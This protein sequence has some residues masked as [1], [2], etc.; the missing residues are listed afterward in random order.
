[1]AYNTIYY[2]TFPDAVG[3]TIDVYIKQKDYAGAPELLE[4][5]TDPVIVTTTNRIYPE[6]VYGTGATIKII[7]TS[8][9][10]LKYTRL[11]GTPEKENYVLIT[12]DTST[13]IFEGYIIPD[14]YSQE[15]RNNAEISLPASNYLSSLDKQELEITQPN[16]IYTYTPGGFQANNLLGNAIWSTDLSIDIA[17]NNTVYSDQMTLSDSS[18][19]FDYIVIN[20]NLYMRENGE[21]ESSKFVIE[22]LLK[23]F[24]SRI[25]YHDGKF[26]IE[27]V[28][29]LLTENKTFVNYSPDGTRSSF[30]LP[31]ERISLCTDNYLIG[32]NTLEFESGKKCIDV[33][34]NY[35]KADNIL[36]KNIWEI[37]VSTGDKPDY[38]K[39]I[40]HVESES[41][42]SSI[43]YEEY[44]DRNIDNGVKLT[45]ADITTT[46]LQWERFLTTKIYLYPA[47]FNRY[48]IS[49]KYSFATQ[50]AKD[51]RTYCA[52]FRLRTAN[53]DDESTYSFVGRYTDPSGEEK[54]KWYDERD[55]TSA[56]RE[57]ISLTYFQQ[58]FTQ[59]DI[60]PHTGVLEVNVDVDLTDLLLDG[61][62]APN[63][64]DHVDTHRTRPSTYSNTIPAVEDDRSLAK[65]VYLD[66]HPLVYRVIG[67]NQAQNQTSGTTNTLLITDIFD[68]YYTL[69]SPNP[70]P[71]Y[72]NI[73]PMAENPQF[74]GD[75]NIDAQIDEEPNKLKGCT[76]SDYV[77]ALEVNL[78]VFDVKSDVYL[79]GIY[80]IDPSE[81]LVKQQ[82]WRDDTSINYLSIQ[83]LLIQDL[84]QQFGK[85][86][87]KLNID[88]KCKD[89]SLFNMGQV[90][91]YSYLTKDGSLME[92][93]PTGMEYNVQANSYRLTLLEA[94][95]D[96][97]FRIDASGTTPVPYM[98]LNPQF[99]LNP[100]DLY[101]YASGYPKTAFGNVV[102]V[103]TNIFWW[104]NS[105]IGDSWIVYDGLYDSFLYTH[106]ANL[107]VN[108]EPNIATYDA[109]GNQL[110][111]FARDGS[112]RFYPI[113]F[114]DPTEYANTWKIVTV[115]QDADTSALFLG[116]DKGYL[117]FDG[118]GNACGD[119]SIY[120]NT[121]SAWYSYKFYDV[122]WVTIVDPSASGSAIMNLT[123][124]ANAGAGIRYEHVYVRSYAD[125]GKICGFTI[126][127]Y[128]TGV[129]C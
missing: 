7:N 38:G 22:S 82:Y 116:I 25:Y 73:L 75:V 109:E 8:T 108:T 68:Y 94:V 86:R 92:F 56:S 16:Y 35:K 114:T 44:S 84:T 74:L 113:G 126:Q 121:S 20:R 29:D 43:T 110:S 95:Q 52:A 31:N 24:Y 81:S 9:D 78:D 100:S 15:I 125:P 98:E 55:F 77:D 3:S 66:I 42:I 67:S 119:S 91:T 103:S 4:L 47:E 58:C 21:S 83:R 71:H 104:A 12:K 6:T 120:I 70:Y 49:Y 59:S 54:F 122:D 39:W 124:D 34:L 99:Y 102:E 63:F 41:A 10:L 88:V 107:L 115:H 40:Y 118:S 111:G 79:N 57:E 96:E 14:L 128:G 62:Y 101:F 127:Q 30:T 36:N 23:T 5:G 18:T 89:A 64:V 27:R 19:L 129:G 80:T 97:D 48:T 33:I 53:A 37:E 45:D 50:H 105:T 1:M 28:K 76:E 26:Y 85:P 117:I 87:Y 17:V 69:T 11:F 112:V 65:Y 61:I 90:F 72:N 106:S 93:I 51:N 46:P 123:I 2:A 13:I 32:N 60:N